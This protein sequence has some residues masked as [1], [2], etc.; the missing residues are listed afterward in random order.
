[1]HGE[2]IKNDAFCF[3]YKRERAHIIRYSEKETIPTPTPTTNALVPTFLLLIL[4]K[5]INGIG[6]GALSL[7]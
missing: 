5:T 1:M 7:P 4:A 6:C 3:R 2:I